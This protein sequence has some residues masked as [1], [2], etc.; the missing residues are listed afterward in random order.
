M[1]GRGEVIDDARSEIHP[2]GLTNYSLISAKNQESLCLLRARPLKLVKNGNDFGENTFLLRSDF[3][4]Y[5]AKI[6]SRKA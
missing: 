4:I 3:A 1:A 5:E 2:R 6:D